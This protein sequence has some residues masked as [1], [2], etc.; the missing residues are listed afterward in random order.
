MLT[1]V[2]K[3]GSAYKAPLWKNPPNPLQDLNVLELS[4]RSAF[5]L[6]QAVWGIKGMSWGSACSCRA[7]MLLGPWRRAGLAPMTGVS[8]WKGAGSLGRTGWAERRGVALYVRELLERRELCLGMD[9]KPVRAY[10]LGFKRTGEGD[11]IVGVCCR[12]PHPEEPVDRA[13]CRQVRAASSFHALVLVWDFSH[14]NICLHSRKKAVHWH[15]LFLN[16]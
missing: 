10:G 14:S 8:W 5:I 6:A 3:Q 7:V 15:R 4:S 13:L 9:E 2:C 16:V 11:I 12:P 1:L